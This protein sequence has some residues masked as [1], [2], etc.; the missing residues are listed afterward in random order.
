[1]HEDFRREDRVDGTSDR[2]FGLVFVAVFLLIALVPL[3]HG[4]GPR[5]WSFAV[6][7]AVAVVA[8]FVPSVLGPL[9]RLW[10]KFGSLLHKIVSPV[11]LGIMF[12]MVIT[13]IGVI[14]RLRGKDLLRLRLDPE[15]QTYW[16]VRTPPGPRAESFVDQF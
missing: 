7:L 5:I 12:F 6:A 2:R 4:R 11:V 16:I 8:L 3:I 10:V 14:M 13:P 9:N 1:M 15:T